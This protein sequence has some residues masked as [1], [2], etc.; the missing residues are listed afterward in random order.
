MLV[1]KCSGMIKKFI[2]LVLPGILLLSCKKETINIPGTA[3]LPVPAS[4]LTQHNDNSRAGLNDQEKILTASNVNS[5]QFGRLYTLS[6]D[7]E[8]YSQPLVFVNL[9]IGTGRHNVV[10]IAT[11]NNTVYA[12]DGDNG[13]LYWEENFTVPGMRPPNTSDMTSDIINPYLDFTH[14][15]G[16]VGTPVIDSLSHTIYFVSRSTDGTN[17]YQYLHAVNITNGNER[18]GSPVVIQASVTGTGQGSVNHV[19]SFDPRRNNQR[20]GLTLVKGV[21]YITYSSHADWSPYHGWILGYNAQNLKQSVIYNDSPD[22]NNGG[23]WESGMGMAA[24]ALGNLYVT[25]GNG[26]VGSY[27]GI[28]DNEPSPDPANLRNRSESALKL[29]PS[30]STLNVSSYF[31]PSNYFD[32]NINDQDYGSMGTFLIPNSNYYFTGCKGGSLFLLNK[33]N[34]GGYSSSSNNVQQTVQIQGDLHCQPAYYKG[35]RNEFVYVW[36]ERDQ[37]RAL[38]F[39]RGS[40]TFF[41]TQILS[42]IIGPTGESGGELSVSSNGSV[43]GTGILWAAHETGNNP[44]NGSGQG[45]LRA[46]DANDITRELWNT[47]MNS[48]DNPGNFAKFSP[49]TIANGHVYLATFSKQVMVYGLR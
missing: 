10:F 9:A 33:D 36:S 44:G 34:M 21:I 20:Q 1:L 18:P 41:N 6:V 26:T 2:F 15:I 22:G 25:T 7:D 43:D 46:F 30:G 29:T 48:N 39:D 45:I 42:D 14:N 40:N 16:I 27:N 5:R 12:F 28:S 49:P 35:A 24:D 8:V 37:L 11:V 19:V 38:S 31:T 4:V 17:F 23:I 47:D 32:L 13:N 3:A